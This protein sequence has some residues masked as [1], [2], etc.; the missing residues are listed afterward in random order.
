M[1]R[2]TRALAFLFVGIVAF[3]AL[4]FVL[5]TSVTYKPYGV[6][7]LLREDYETRV[8][9]IKQRNRLL[10]GEVEDHEKVPLAQVE[11]TEFDFGRLNPHDTV[12]HD[13]IVKNVGLSP[14]ALRVRETSCKCTVGELEDS[15]LQP[16]ESTKVTMTWNTGMKAEVYEQS[17]VLAT[18]DPFNKTITITVRGEIKSELVVPK[19]VW[20][21]KGDVG[22]RLRT[23]FFVS[24]QLWD[25]F[26]IE[27]VLCD[28]EDFEWYVEPADLN[29]PKLLELDPKSAWKVVF[30]V[31]VYEQGQFSGEA[32]LVVNPGTGEPAVE[33][34]LSFGGKTRSPIAFVGPE[35]D[36][37]N[38]VD[39][40][41]QQSDRRH[42]FSFLARV[43][44]NEHRKIA[45]LDHQ[46][47]E[48]ETAIQPTGREGDYRVTISIP[49]GCPA[50]NFNRD[51]QHGYVQVGDPDDPTFQNWLPIYGAVFQLNK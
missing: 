8:S 46:P 28:R 48:L 35:V 6:P 18:N 5:A 45:I 47:P 36:S 15:L 26:T 29:A 22:S 23:S 40:E 12:S 7:D 50:V 51:D 25:G 10:S 49:K 21:G 13:F 31:P 1:N 16:G 24:S 19:S 32:R 43:R 3:G 33:R 41:T 2:L 38:G 34:T 44:G 11:L 37:R 42:D 14:L 17:A 30:E 20:L 39:L 4:T 27:D 9:E